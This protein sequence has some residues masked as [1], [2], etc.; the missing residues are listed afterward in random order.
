MYQL[1]ICYEDLVHY[2]AN[3]SGDCVRTFT[4]NRDGYD[5]NVV[6]NRHEAEFGKEQLGGA[7]HDS[8]HDVIACFSCDCASSSKNACTVI[9]FSIFSELQESNGGNLPQIWQ[10]TPWAGRTATAIGY[11]VDV[12][13]NA[14]MLQP[15]IVLCQYLKIA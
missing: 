1:L 4:E 5:V 12:V 11:A 2:K 9:G 14:V 7:D 8:G 13:R 3:A 15:T 10:P 6:V